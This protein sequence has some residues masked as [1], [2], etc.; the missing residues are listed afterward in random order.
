MESR[1]SGRVKF[2]VTPK[3]PPLISHRPFD[4]ERVHEIVHSKTLPPKVTQDLILKLLR[5][6]ERECMSIEGG[7]ER[8]RENKGEKRERDL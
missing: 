6:K 7:R 5:G 4:V 3:L 2:V 8:G 1:T